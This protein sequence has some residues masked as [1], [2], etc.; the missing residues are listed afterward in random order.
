[1][2]NKVRKGLHDIITPGGVLDDA[3]NPQRK[4]LGAASLELK[5]A[6]CEKVREAA[7]KR[8]VEMDRKIADLDGEITRLLGT[9]RG[10]TPGRTPPEAAFPPGRGFTLRY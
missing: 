2:K 1:M 9:S 8:I 5:K 10:P 6:L 3:N 7:R 4:Y